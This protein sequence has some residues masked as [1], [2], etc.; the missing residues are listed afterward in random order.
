[1]GNDPHG[2]VH[3]PP[4]STPRPSQPLNGITA[5]GQGP[6]AA[7]AA[8]AAMAA[9]PQGQVAGGRA[10]LAHPGLQ[11]QGPGGMGGTGGAGAGAQGSSDDGGP[12]EEEQ[13]DPLR[14]GSAVGW[15]SPGMEL[16][17]AN[18]L[19][20]RRAGLGPGHNL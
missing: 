19:R 12:E 9:T 11:Q 20:V 1:M 18:E 14:R 10:P 15:S 8:A 2:R 6:G 13:L 4:E 17:V 16:K 5:N 3:H 7:T